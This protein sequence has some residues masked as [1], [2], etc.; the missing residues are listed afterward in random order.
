MLNRRANLP[1]T[2]SATLSPGLRPMNFTTSAPF[3]DGSLTASGGG[4]AGVCA[5]TVAAVIASA[6]P[7]AAAVA[8]MGF[9]VVMFV[10][11]KCCA[12]AVTDA[13]RAQATLQPEGRPRSGGRRAQLDHKMPA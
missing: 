11:P 10:L 12:Q 9:M 4:P 7:R 8:L 5:A 1:G 2:M 6:R 13:R 3:S